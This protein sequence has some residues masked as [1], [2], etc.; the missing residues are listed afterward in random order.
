MEKIIG[1]V[2]S[3]VR[4]SD[5]HNL[6]SLYT[7]TRGRITFISA[8]G[9]SGKSGRARQARLMPLSVVS[10]DV[11]F[12]AGRELQKLGSIAPERVWHSIYSN[13]AKTGIA[14]FI[15]EFLNRLLRE[16]APD[17]A[18]WSYLLHSLEAFDA[19]A[20]AA[21]NFHIALLVGLLPHAGIMPDVVGAKIPE[22]FTFDMRGGTFSP[23]A[24]LHRD[25]VAWPES[26]FIP[27]LARITTRNM[28]RFRLTGAMRR[29]ILAA[30]VHYYAVHLP[31]V[32]GLRSADILAEVFG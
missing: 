8:A 12:R 9:A 26:A 10:A 6:V 14:L 7:P 1:I 16:S 18:T 2:L 13:P 31:G 3:V 11:R 20:G 17:P 15:A 32:A 21:P 23:D 29:R 27:V 25:I 5:R 30:L 19:A 28:A 24:P 22:A 4:H